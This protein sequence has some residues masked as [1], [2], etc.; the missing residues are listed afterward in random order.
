MW[1][2]GAARRRERRGVAEPAQGRSGGWE[3][4]SRLRWPGWCRRSGALPADGAG[5]R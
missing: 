5:G 3:R 1:D 2:T 4:A